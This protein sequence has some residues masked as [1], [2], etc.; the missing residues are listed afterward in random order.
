MRTFPSR[1]WCFAVMGALLALSGCSLVGPPTALAPP[2]TPL[3]PHEVSFWVKP[4]WPHRFVLLA[5]LDTSLLGW[6][7]SPGLNCRILEKLRQQ[8][9]RMGAN[10]VL[11]ADPPPSGGGSP[12]MGNGNMNT[13]MAGNNPDFGDQTAPSQIQRMV[14]YKGYAA[15]VPT[16]PQG[17]SPTGVALP[18]NC[19]HLTGGTPRPPPSHP[20][21]SAPP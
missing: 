3:P 17:K 2:R 21:R 15:Y 8:A 16:H 12:G 11:L 9:A 4:A 1:S 13:G 20:A 19:R 5:K 7:N 14:T 10:A 18:P 6:D